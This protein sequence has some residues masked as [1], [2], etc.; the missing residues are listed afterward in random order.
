MRVLSDW[1]VLD[2]RIASDYDVKVE[3]VIDW[4]GDEEKVVTI[5]CPTVDKIL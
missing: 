2:K 3:K 1:G 5:K 4:D